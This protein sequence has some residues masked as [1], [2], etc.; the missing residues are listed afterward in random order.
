MMR[1]ASDYKRS[2]PSS[3]EIILL[4]SN[5]VYL[6]LKTGTLP[7]VTSKR[8]P[9]KII[10]S[11]VQQ[12]PKHTLKIHTNTVFENSQMQITFERFQTLF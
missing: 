11:L 3:Q 2:S 4:G 8:R 5:K 9:S 1:I 10:Y 7:P 6:Y 12:L